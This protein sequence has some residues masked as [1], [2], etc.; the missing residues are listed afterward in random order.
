M[1]QSVPSIGMQSPQFSA[2]NSN[3]KAPA[4]SVSFKG[5]RNPLRK[6][7]V[8]CA[9]RNP[10]N[11]MVKK[12]LNAI[13]RNLPDLP[14]ITTAVSVAF[15][16]GVLHHVNKVEQR[17]LNRIEQIHAKPIEEN[18]SKNLK[19]TFDASTLKETAKTAVDT[20]AKVIKNH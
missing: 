7:R 2:K 14:S 16:F 1:I 15:T 20:A 6:S 19:N 9:S 12:V 5:Y 3:S 8:R 4:S 13:D 11:K 10:S 18:V 17:I